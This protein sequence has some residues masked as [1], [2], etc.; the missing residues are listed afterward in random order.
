MIHAGDA[1][2]VDNAENLLAAIKMVVDNI[3][4]AAIQIKD[5]SVC[6]KLGLK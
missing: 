6:E 4:V 3:Q 1:I 2:L 5:Q